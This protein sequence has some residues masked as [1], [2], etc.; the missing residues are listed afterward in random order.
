MR[1]PA[2]GRATRAAAASNRRGGIVTMARAARIGLTGAVALA[3]GW[4]VAQAA[5]ALTSIPALRRAAYPRL[6]G[7][8]ARDH[9]ALTFDDGP[10]P[11]YTPAL[12]AILDRLQVKAT[13]FLLGHMLAANRQIGR[14]LVAAG[15]EVG[16]H[17][18]SHRVLL[19]RSPAAT[20]RDLSRGRDLIAEVTGQPVRWWRPP[21]GVL[22]ASSLVSAYQLGLTPVLWT[23][24]GRDW[25]ESAT[26][27]SVRTTVTRGLRPGGTILLHDSDCTSAAGSSRATLAALPA[28]VHDIRA[29]NWR[30]GP[31][32]EHSL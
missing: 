9:V 23:A 12:I 5:P 32:S 14:D 24:W 18:W 22:T 30:V 8:G 17:G 15:H 29:H 28:L 20:H 3:V 21:Y 19:G 1:H 10:D 16:L 26:A 7:I 2:S 6:A 13:F 31:L 11:H 25:T 4:S 27:T